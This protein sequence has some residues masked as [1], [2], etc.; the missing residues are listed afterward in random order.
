[1]SDQQ[2]V[3]IVIEHQQGRIET[4]GTLVFINPQ[5][6]PASGLRTLK[7]MTPNPAAEIIPGISGVMVLEVTE[8]AA[9][10]VSGQ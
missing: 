9:N 2:S 7:A 10:T 3:T 4:E 8:P 1:M 5:I 6:D